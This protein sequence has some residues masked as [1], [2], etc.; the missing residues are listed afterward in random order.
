M[1]LFSKHQRQETA[2]VVPID[3]TEVGPFFG[4]EYKHSLTTSDRVEF[5]WCDRID[6]PGVGPRFYPG[7]ARARGNGIELLVGG[8]LHGVADGSIPLFRKAIAFG[9]GTANVLVRGE[10]GKRE[11][12][13]VYMRV[14]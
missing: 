11:M 12:S 2:Q 10:N 8:V 4:L 3:V 9:G 5:G 13:E 6:W 1:G 14:R 7:I